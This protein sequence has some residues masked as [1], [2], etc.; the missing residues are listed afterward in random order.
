M[1]NPLI[2]V[3]VEVCA[4]TSTFQ[5]TA[6]GDLRQYKISNWPTRVR[7]DPVIASQILHITNAM[8]YDMA[9]YGILANRQ[10]SVR[11]YHRLTDPQEESTF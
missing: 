9:M 5:V 6:Q 8:F 10:I 3:K 11:Q 4:G 7:V 2:N 1:A